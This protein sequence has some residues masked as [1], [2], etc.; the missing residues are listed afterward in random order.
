MIDLKD[1]VILITGASKGIGYYLV[2]R[3]LNLGAK[4]IATSRK[5]SNFEKLLIAKND[6]FIPFELDLIDTGNISLFIDEINNNDLQVDIL[7]NNAGIAYFQK[8]EDTTIDNISKTIDVNF[9]NTVTLTKLLLPGMIERQ[10]GVIANIL[11]GA[12]ER[13]FAYS[14]VYSGTKAAIRALSR[15]LREE[16]RDKNIKIMDI[17][18]G[19]TSTEIWDKNMLDKFS[20]RMIHPKDLAEVILT[21]IALSYLPNIMIEDIIIKPQLGD[22]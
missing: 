14:S 6:N 11:S 4:V 15:S 22:L 18:P 2:E 13:N 17:L 12:I 9:K 19:A 1:K 20:D 21:N 7:I 16:V 10:T 3:A 8:L 5:I